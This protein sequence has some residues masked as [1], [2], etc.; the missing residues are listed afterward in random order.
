MIVLDTNVLSE[1]F[2]PRP[3]P[4]VVRWLENLTG[5]AAVTAVTVAELLAGV[6]RLP[7]GRRKW[8]L[9]AGIDNV[10]RSYRNSRAILPFD[11][12]AAEHYATILSTRESAGSPIS[13]ADAQI[14]AICRA[15]G[16]V[17]ATRNTRDFTGT[18]VEL[19]NPWVA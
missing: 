6:Q 8:D 4:H 19:I 15:N 18:G 10:L 5:D 12:A 7:D 13:T 11:T 14:A 16:A 2:R 1:V 9:R 17:C 3:D